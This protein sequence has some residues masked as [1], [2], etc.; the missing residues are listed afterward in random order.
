MIRV[1]RPNGRPQ[2]A[3][4]LYTVSPHF[5]LYSRVA[6]CGRPLGLLR[7]L[8]LS[9]YLGLPCYFVNVHHYTLLATNPIGGLLK[10]LIS[11]PNFCTS[12]AGC[13]ELD[14]YGY[15]VALVLCILIILFAILII[16]LFTFYRLQPHDEPQTTTQPRISVLVPAR[17][18]E[19]SIERCIRS[20]VAQTYEP[21][22]VFVLDDHSSD[23]TAAIVQRVIDELPPQKQGRLRLLQGEE[24]P[25][26]WGGKNFA[27]HQ[28]AQQA[29]GDFLF[30]TD[31]DTVHDP[32]MVASVID[33]MQRRKVALLTAQPTYELD[34]LG[35]RL[36]V[37]LL[38]F[39][40]MTLLPVALIPVRPEPSL[41]TG[42]G[43]L[44]CFERSAYEHI[45]GHASVK[46][47]ILEDVLLARAVK[48]AGY[49]MIFVDAQD[50]V[51]CRMYH[52]FAEVW[53]GFSKNLF[54][55]YNYALPFALVGLVLNILLFIVP[56]LLVI[57]AL[58]VP[59]SPTTL[60]LAISAY[61]LPALMRVLLTLR[62]T[63]TQRGMMLL[64]CLLHPVSIALECLILL[65]SIRW[66]YRKEGTLWKGR[67]YA[68]L[69]KHK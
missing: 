42:N 35:E 62:F 58:F 41:A 8:S 52:S 59:L 25:A 15:V 4:L 54:A 67:H 68:A 48:A 31:A 46:N 7:Y 38:T 1:F 47:R 28:L 39:A 11:S 16:N 64:L 32:K 18:E 2:G 43:Q 36:I 49:H 21:L 27:C 61:V 63:H 65:N 9:R 20:L 53:S 37:P 12:P 45:G 40:V 23:T 57:S 56:I 17:N 26:G 14:P 13:N 55:F 50:L 10:R 3:T 33:C 34:S 6:P 51:R 22:E 66:H 60:I 29:S 30:F 44:L 5:Q 19:Q 69:Q 24:L